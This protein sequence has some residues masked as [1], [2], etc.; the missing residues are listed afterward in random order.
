MPICKEL[1]A[2]HWGSST[3]IVKTAESNKAH[4]KATK[5]SICDGAYYNYVL[6]HLD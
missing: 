2:S 3:I 6:E 5:G 4:Q 1:L